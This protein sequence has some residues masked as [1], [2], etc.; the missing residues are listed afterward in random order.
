MEDDGRKNSS[1]STAC[2]VT[3]LPPDHKK[4]VKNGIKCKLLRILEVI[5]MAVIL[6]FILG[7]LMVSAFFFTFPLLELTP[8]SSHLAKYSHFWGV[9]ELVS[10]NNSVDI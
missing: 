1:T 6:A 8:V 4:Q 7:F 3:V 9:D 2:S 5:L 10:P